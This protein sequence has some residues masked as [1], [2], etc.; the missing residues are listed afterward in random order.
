MPQFPIEQVDA[1][2]AEFLCGCGSCTYA[3][4]GPIAREKCK[5][6]RIAEALAAARMEGRL[7]IAKEVG[8]IPLENALRHA[9]WAATCAEG[10]AAACAV[11]AASAATASVAG[12]NREWETRAVAHAASARDTVTM[13]EETIKAHAAHYDRLSGNTESVPKRAPARGDDPP[14]TPS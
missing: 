4:A 13:L 10:D 11:I 12:A 9:R 6:P 8:S 2:S 1:H 5:A 7:D 3:S 14:R